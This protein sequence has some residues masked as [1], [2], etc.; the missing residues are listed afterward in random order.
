VYNSIISA[1]LVAPGP[2][3]KC[4]RLGK[5]TEH[6]EGNLYSNNIND[7]DKNSINRNQG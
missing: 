7:N 6:K 4:P 5:E 2:I 1:S 3:T